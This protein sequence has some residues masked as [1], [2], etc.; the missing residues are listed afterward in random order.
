MFIE[1]IYPT[2]SFSI[3]S[4]E[5]NSLLYSMRLVSVILVYFHIYITL[6]TVFNLSIA[7]FSWNILI[8]E[9]KSFDDTKDKLE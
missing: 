1:C 9:S 4:S 6:H 8:P 7:F 2:T 3:S 5:V